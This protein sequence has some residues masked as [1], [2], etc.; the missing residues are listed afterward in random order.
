MLVKSSGSTGPL[1]VLRSTDCR[2]P[3]G[4]QELEG[5]PMR[6]ASEGLRQV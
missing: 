2:A 6:G 1:K 4:R 3:W 5:Q